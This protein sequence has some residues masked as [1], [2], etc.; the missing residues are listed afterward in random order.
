MEQSQSGKQ[1]VYSPIKCQN[2]ILHIKMVN[3]HIK[4]QISSIS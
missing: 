2:R 1:E 4:I 3:L